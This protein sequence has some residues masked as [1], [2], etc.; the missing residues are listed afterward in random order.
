MKKEAIERINR[1]REFYMQ[2]PVF[3]EWVG[4]NRVRR[5]RLNFMRASFTCGDVSAESAQSVWES[6]NG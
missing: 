3:C 2:G 5:Q 6:L 4:F 1:I